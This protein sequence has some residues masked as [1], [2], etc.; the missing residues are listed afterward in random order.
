MAS[1]RVTAAQSVNLKW[2]MC[3][4]ALRDLVQMFEIEKP[5]C[6]WFGAT[7]W[8]V[9]SA[10]H[11]AKLSCSRNYFDKVWYKPIEL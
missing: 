10:F 3:V 9:T 11:T 2:A 6:L 1:L 8:I 5:T 7:R 4:L